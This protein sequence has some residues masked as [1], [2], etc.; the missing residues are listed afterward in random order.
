M[1]EIRVARTRSFDDKS[2]IMVKFQKEKK[3]KKSDKFFPPRI[4]KFFYLRSI[5]S[6]IRISNLWR[7]RAD[8]RKRKPSVDRRSGSHMSLA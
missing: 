3:K 2:S 6:H 4:W 7:Q 1:R 5:E 8:S